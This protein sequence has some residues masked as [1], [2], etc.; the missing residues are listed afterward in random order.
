MVLLKYRNFSK[1]NLYR[2]YQFFSGI[3]LCS[4]TNVVTKTQNETLPLN[5]CDTRMQLW[6]KLKA[7]HNER[8]LSQ[9]SN[10]LQIRMQ[11]GKT[12]EGVANQT[13]PFS[14]YKA[15][16]GSV[17]DG[18]VASVN[19]QLWDM[20]RPLEADCTIELL[21]FKDPLA[22]EVF[23]RSSAHILG[24][25][26]GQLYGNVLCSGLATT[27]GFYYDMLHGSQTVCS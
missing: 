23:W 25:A 15:I 3:R 26:M 22:K 16:D 24:A 5:G 7:E 6:Q 1:D 4:T 2:N 11:N 8:I 20:S 21:T 12:Y 17:N 13:T 19:G 10:S 14:I 18:L 9:P 27:G